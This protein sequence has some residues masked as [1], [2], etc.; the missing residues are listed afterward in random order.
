VYFFEH[1][2]EPSGCHKIYGIS[3]LAEQ[4]LASQKGLCILELV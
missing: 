1:T 3:W 2:N 4:L